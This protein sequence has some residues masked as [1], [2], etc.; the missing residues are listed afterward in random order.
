MTSAD[1][2][3]PLLNSL[4]DLLYKRLTVKT[5]VRD[6]A[7]KIHSLQVINLMGSTE[8]WFSILKLENQ[9]QT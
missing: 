2:R 8:K 9:E 6:F 4:P 3:H 1:L 7:M 5:H